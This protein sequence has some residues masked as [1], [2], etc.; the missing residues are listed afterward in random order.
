MNLQKLAEFLFFFLFFCQ[1]VKVVIK[2]KHY[3]IALKFGTLKGGIRVH[4]DTKF[5]CDT[6]NGHKF[7]NDYSQKNSTNMLS[8]LQGKLLM[9]RS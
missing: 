8:C 6:I 3:P 4:P 2:H 9:A 7:I 5:G 1:G